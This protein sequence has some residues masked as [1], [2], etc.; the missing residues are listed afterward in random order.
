M[1][2]FG[3]V[4]VLDWGLARMVDQAE[5]EAESDD[6]P[7]ISISAEA[8]TPP[9][10]GT[11]GTPQYMAPEQVEGRRDLID[12]RTDVYALGGILFEILTGRPPA[13]GETVA[14]IY[15]AILAGSIPRARELV[16][17]VPR[18]LEAICARALARDRAGR[19]ARAVD[20]AEDVRRWIADEPVSAW[21]DPFA[22]RARRWA[23]RNRTAVTAAAVAVLVGLV[24]LVGIVAVQTKARND[25]DRKNVE[26]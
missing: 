20:L 24:G 3:E 18:P 26:V 9:S 14:E 19:Y 13:I 4:I 11:S 6:T 7:R 16:P 21:P 17:S 25:L 1:G 5:E 10:I 2:E 22:E 8:V 15:G 23:K 12:G